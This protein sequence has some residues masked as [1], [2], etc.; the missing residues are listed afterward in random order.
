MESPAHLHEV[1]KSSKNSI[2]NRTLAVASL[3]SRLY[4]QCFLVIVLAPD[5]ARPDGH[6][7][8]AQ[9]QLQ[10]FP[11][12]RK[13]G[14]RGRHVQRQVLE[15]GQ[16]EAAR[17]GRDAAGVVVSAHG[18]AS[19]RRLASA[20]LIRSAMS[21]RSRVDRANRSRRLPP[22]RRRGGDAQAHGRARATYLFF[23][24]PYATGFA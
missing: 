17:F 18:S 22:P 9:P 10:G 2:K 6:Q 5:K 24:A 20:S 16:I 15:L 4:F 8:G 12:A 23:E 3:A 11:L 19:D 7:A 21:S 14:A 1:P 13:A